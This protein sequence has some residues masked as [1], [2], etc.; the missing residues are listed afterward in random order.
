M[1]PQKKKMAGL[2]DAESWLNSQQALDLGL[3]DN[4]TDSIKMAA[5]FDL[6]K[7]KYHHIPEQFK[8]QNMDCRQRLAKQ[9]MACQ[10]IRAASG[11]Q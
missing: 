1:E 9:S 7:F 11:R 8:P 2:M 3:I 10:K 5:S 4:I 6:S